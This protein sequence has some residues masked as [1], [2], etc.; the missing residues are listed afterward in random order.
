[1]SY[2]NSVTIIAFV[3]ADPEQRS[4]EELIEVHRSVRRHAALLKERARRVD[5][6]SRVAPRCDFPLASRQR[7]PCDSPQGRTRNGGRRAGQLDLRPAEWQRQEQE[8]EDREGHVVVH[9][10]RCGAPARPCINH[11]FRQGLGVAAEAFVFY[12][13]Q[14]EPY[15]FG[16][17]ARDNN[18]LDGLLSSQLVSA[19][20]SARPLVAPFEPPRSSGGSNEETASEALEIVQT[21]CSDVGNRA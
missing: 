16:L 17:C 20:Y 6:E 18:V 10:R 9:S 13:L 1:M 8:S 11:F 15:R 2:M 19:A 4:A 5:L 7:C 12:R 21:L 3:G 14:T